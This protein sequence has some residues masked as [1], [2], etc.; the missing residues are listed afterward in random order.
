MSLKIEALSAVAEKGKLNGE[1][2]VVVNE[3]D[4]A[5]NLDGCSI[6]VSR[7]G[8]SKARVA[9]TLKAG[10]IVQPK[11]RC[12]LITGSSGRGSH[13]QAP[14][15]EGVR[16]FYLYLKAPYLDKPGITVKLMNRQHEI[17]RAVFDPEAEGGLGSN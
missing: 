6:A 13:G 11:E 16:N 1:W 9:T 10:L 12:R 15:E 8:K 14:E 2:M 17:C 4:R 3:G 7:G 5:I